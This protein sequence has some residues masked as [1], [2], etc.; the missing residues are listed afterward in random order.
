MQLAAYLVIDA[1][2]E[3]RAPSLHS[4]PYVPVHCLSVPALIS[5]V[6]GQCVLK[7]GAAVDRG[8]MN[9][10]TTLYCAE[11]RDMNLSIF[12]IEIVRFPFAAAL[13]NWLLAAL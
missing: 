8:K 2:A 9:L 13:K 4:G 7:E 6:L 11:L 5:C 10:A 1:I 3:C 12:L